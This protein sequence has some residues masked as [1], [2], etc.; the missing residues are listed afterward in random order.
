MLVTYCSQEQLRKGKET[1][2]RTALGAPRIRLVMQM[3]WESLLI[4]L[5]SGVLAVLF[6]GLWLEVANK[7]VLESFPFDPP[8]W[9]NIQNHRKPL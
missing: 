9:W 3:M 6:A 1:A 5:I 8:F 7:D 4:C 2:I